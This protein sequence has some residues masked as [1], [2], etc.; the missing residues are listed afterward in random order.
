[1]SFQEVKEAREAIQDLVA[2]SY[3]KELKR[4]P[5][6]RAFKTLLALSTTGAFQTGEFL[7]NSGL[8]SPIKIESDLLR[9]E[10]KVHKEISS[11]LSEVIQGKEIHTNMVVGVISGGVSF[12]EEVAGML[13][14]RSSA[15]LG[16][17]KTPE[18]QAQVEGI[19]VPGDSVIIIEDVITTGANT[20]AC[21]RQV[22]EEGGKILGAM[23]IFN[24]GLEGA[25]WEFSER[26]WKVDS[27]LSF[28]QLMKFLRKG[29]ETLGAKG[30]EDPYL[31]AWLQSLQAWHDR[32]PTYRQQTLD[33]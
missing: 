7:F 6:V 28:E 33:L 10:P 12:A 20:L 23:S 21:A 30:E 3:Q 32:I 29:V 9:A 22:K 15:R 24:Y 16:N 14:V 18:K 4:M 5:T 13:G 27:L 2:A 1:M 25:A 19:I 8:A 31:A 17:T 26:G 11:M